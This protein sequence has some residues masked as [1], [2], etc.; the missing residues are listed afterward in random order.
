[1]K[2]AP[3]GL[4]SLRATLHL[5]NDMTRLKIDVLGGLQIRL[6]GQQ[7]SPAFPTRKSKA[8]LVYLALSPG[9]LR[10]RAQLASVFWERSAEE[11]ARASLRQTL[12][13]LRRILPNAPPL[14]RAES[15]AV[16]LDE[17]SVEVDAL[18]FRRLA[19]DRSAASL[20]NAVAL[21]RGVLLDGFGLREEP[22]E[23]WM[24]LE[25]RWFH[26][27]AVDV[28]T[29]LA[30]HYERSG[31]MD[32]AIAAASRVLTLDPTLE[33]AHAVLMKLY[34]RTGHRNAAVR[35]YQECVRA[36]N[37]ELGIAPAESTQRLAAQ[38]QRDAHREPAGSAV[39]IQNLDTQT[40]SASRTGYE[41]GNATILPAERKHLSVL[42]ARVRQPVSV[43]D[44]ETALERVDA[45]LK[46]MAD[47]VQRFGGLVTQVR[48]DGVTAL[49]GAPVAQ[50]EHAVEACYAA[51]AMRERISELIGRSLEVRIG[52]HSG[53]A[54]VRA[55]GEGGSQHYDALGA[56]PQVANQID[57][58]LAAGEIGVSADTVRCAE[59]FIQLSDDRARP[60]PGAAPPIDI[61]LLRTK[62]DLRLRW[63]ARTVRGLTQLVGRDAEMSALRG[64]LG[65][66]GRGAGQV[67]AIVGDP[68]VGKSRLV[69]EFVNSEQAAGWTIVETGATSRDTRAI[70]LPLANLLRTWFRIAARDS[71]DEAA[72]KLRR[73]VEAV[74]PALASACPALSAMLD[75][76]PDDPQWDMAS[77]PQKR[78]LTLEAV[79][80]FVICAN[81]THPL[82]LVVE[83]LHWIDE[84]TQAVLDHLV[85]FIGASRILLLVTHRPEYRHTWFGKSYF[86]QLHVDNLDAE[87]AKVLLQMLLGDGSELSTLR[88]RLIERTGCTP[89]FLEESVRALADTG[90]LVGRKGAYQMARTIDTPD[91]PSTVHAVL[92]SRIDRLPAE[93]KSLMQMAA[94]IGQEFS[95]DVLQPIADLDRERLLD[96]LTNLQAAEFLYQTQ[97][98]PHQQY[99]FKHALTHRVAYASVLKERRRSMHIR[100]VDVI[101]QLYAQRLDEHVERLAHHAIAGELW[102]KAIHYLYQS[103]GKALQRFSYQQA[104]DH[105][106]QGLGIIGTLSPSP[107]LLR[108]ELEYQKVLGVTMMA[109]KGWAAKEVLDA[110]TQ[111]RTLCEALGDK[112]ELFTALRG[113]G[114]YRMIRGESEIAREL[115]NRCIAL[116]ADSHDHGM[117]IETHHLF[118]T[119]SFFMGEYATSEFHSSKGIALY[120]R[121]RD[122][123]LTFKYSGHDPGVCC[124]CFTALAVCLRGYPD[125]ALS[126]CH[127]ALGLAQDLAHPLTT[128]LA[129]WACSFA[130]IL[131][132][133]PEQAK[134]WAEREISICDE[135]MLPLLLSQGQFQL[136]WSVAQTGDLD[137]GIERMREGISAISATGA[138]MGLPFFN[139][140]LGEA[141]GRAG[142]PEAGLAEIER[143]LAIVNQ[144]GGRFQ[145]SEILRLKA[146][147]L[148]TGDFAQQDEILAILLEAIAIAQRQGASLPALRAALSLARQLAATGDMRNAY[149]VLQPAC[150]SIMEGGNLA[151]IGT[152]RRLLAEIKQR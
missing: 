94:V 128:A 10:S 77:P 6:A 26:E 78:K 3:G 87:S 54:V 138:E 68:G 56:V 137:E 57:V 111:A 101:E 85:D 145:L 55:I 80:A 109:A 102:D 123:A 152:A 84:G 20:A 32:H 127:E 151:D 7:G 18:Q 67:C 36:L 37:I 43:T 99:T 49:F 139:A 59:G 11:Q 130:H 86:T 41:A 140:L 90:A 48:S 45:V 150:D 60:L 92:A 66:A 148:A 12:S 17:P 143:A 31:E 147:L 53:E 149:A 76:P 73:G 88:R 131:R 144:R 118:W 108:Q 13:S 97:L 62:S 113:E 14:L 116:T 42:C 126:V 19:T 79:A 112:G 33:W 133:E 91:I 81:H 96:L 105:L 117:Q 70:Y 136:G 4:D 100:L 51:L 132:G 72:G 129:Y 16:W 141:L 121:E 146:E 95:V 142:K 65:R 2:V 50:E 27:R 64:M 23:Q 115:G 5:T 34:A 35:Q 38:I 107:A 21:Y 82:I 103:A 122:H 44:H 125:K 46:A 8:I 15:D 29:E 28:L 74:D 135:Y 61:F 63:N 69:H 104:L 106:I 119:N 52:V 40:A 1:M 24:I 114:Q 134:H 47:A 83:D 30:G 89:L 71:L 110:Y 93:E 98:L 25:R 124:R 120:E 39:V 22:F 75:L 58:A 9:M